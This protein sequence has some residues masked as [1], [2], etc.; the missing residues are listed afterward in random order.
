VICALRSRATG[1][2]TA[3]AVLQPQ[4][5]IV[6][7]Q[8]ASRFLHNPTSRLKVAPL[9]RL[10]HLSLALFL[11]FT[12]LGAVMARADVPCVIS[13][14]AGR[15]AMISIQEATSNSI[16]MTWESCTN[17]IYAVLSADEPDA[18]T[19][20]SG[21]FALW[22]ENGTTSWTDTTTINIDHRFYRVVRMPADG[23]FDGDGMPNA[24]ELQYGLNLFDPNDAQTDSDGDGV[25][26]L[27]EFLQG[28]DPT[29]A[30]M[31]DGEGLV[32]LNVFTPL[33]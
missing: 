22:G 1:T 33:E 10:S 31:E 28:R 8:Q 27:T 6:V 4:I 21:R 19:F 14:E 3:A 30:A 5:V 15:F 12:L 16:S 32:N 20:W 18:G 7:T 13:N 9:N 17:Y 26:N 2:D 23:D 25:D 11:A 24:W 29:K